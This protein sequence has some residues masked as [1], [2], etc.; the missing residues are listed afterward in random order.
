MA[1]KIGLALGG[2]DGETIE[3]AVDRIVRA[4]RDGFSTAWLAHI[5]SLDALTVLALA[6]QKTSRIELGTAVIPTYPR[7]PHAL[8][9]QAATVNAAV[10][11]RLALGIGRSHQLVIEN[12][13]GL[14]Y[15]KPLA[16][17]GEYV[18]IIRS[19]VTEGACSVEGK[20][21]NV[22]ASL[23]VK[24]RP[25][26]SILIGAL[27]PKMLDLC[28]R[29]CDGT[30]TWMAG[31]G[32]LERSIVPALRAA[33]EGAGRAMPRVVC[34]LPICVTD[35]KGGAKQ[36]AAKLFEIYGQLPVYR[37]C[38]DAEGAAGPEDLALIG[39]EEEILEGLARVRDAGASDFYAAVFP[40]DGAGASTDRSY[41]LLKGLAGSV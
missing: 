17:M 21:Y 3:G 11:G 31:P 39:S 35:D 12:M 30:L 2:G 7:H 27:M 8:A 6:G 9:Q 25:A 18:Q 19:L 33:S 10:G 26:L 37:A 14:A 41:E 5:F 13:F 16:H 4:E 29:T 34:S 32:Y 20:A 15:D 40:E 23:D 24:E 1:M 22:H 38:I 36:A 28:G